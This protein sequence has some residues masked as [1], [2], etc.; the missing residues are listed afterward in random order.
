[1]QRVP[2]CCRNFFWGDVNKQLPDPYK[3][4]MADQSAILPKSNSGNQ[5]LTYI[6][7]GR[8]C[9]QEHGWY[10][11]SRTNRESHPS[12]DCDFLVAAQTASTSVGLPR[13]MNSG[14]SL[15]KKVAYN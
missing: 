3:V 1:M 9:L 15:D 12:M 5:W 10:Q 13:S 4:P 11:S 7:Q 14:I 2:S 6:A 8:G